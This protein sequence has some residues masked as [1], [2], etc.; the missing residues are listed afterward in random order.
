LDAFVLHGIDAWRSEGRISP[1]EADTLVR[2]LNTPEVA[3]GLMHAGAHFAI[4]LPLRF[5]LGALARFFYTLILR[6]KAEFG[7]LGGESASEARRT[8]TWLVMLL[9]LLPGFG[10]LAYF[11]SPALA[12]HRLLLVIPM[13]QV[14]RKLPLKSYQRLHLEALFIYWGKPTR[15]PDKN[16]GSM[17]PFLARGLIRLRA[18]APLVPLLAAVVAIEAVLFIIGAGIYLDSDRTL[19]WWF[20]ERSVVATMNVVQLVIAAIA[21]ILAYKHFWRDAA[22]VSLEDAAGIFLWGAGG[23]GLLAFVIDD[24]FTIHEQL[25]SWLTSN[26]G[27]LANVTTNADDLLVLFYA[28]CGIGVLIVFRMELRARRN[29]TTL[30]YLAAAMSIVMVLTD[31]FATVEVLKALE[32]PAQSLATT[33]LMFAFVARYLEVRNPTRATVSST[34]GFTA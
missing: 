11:F 27:P 31:A 34:K 33:L 3:H 9:A 21:G 5:P 10:R 16:S 13:D 7:A 28:V 1:A 12:G 18:L 2:S 4:S 14:S 30:L 25:G 24:Y 22:N 17:T 15:P 6:I 20:Q 23:L 26:V 8:H 19:T 32:L 29:S